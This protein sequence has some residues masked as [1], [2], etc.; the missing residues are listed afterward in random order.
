[1]SCGHSINTSSC[2]QLQTLACLKNN[3]IANSSCLSSSMQMF[4][5]RYLY[6]FLFKEQQ[7]SCFISISSFSSTSSIDSSVLQRD[8]SILTSLMVDVWDCDETDIWDMCSIFCP[9]K[10][11]PISTSDFQ[12]KKTISHILT[13]RFGKSDQTGSGALVSRYIKKKPALRNKI[14]WV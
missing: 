12:E 1:M 7:L 14:R 4:G 13:T 5:K 10:L 3:W 2:E 9:D 11:C 6:E 8:V